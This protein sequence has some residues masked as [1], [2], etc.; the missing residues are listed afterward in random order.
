MRN[1]SA[2]Y[3]LHIVRIPQFETAGDFVGSLKLMFQ[4][5]DFQPS[6]IVPLAFFLPMKGNYN[7][8][9]SFFKYIKSVIP[10]RLLFTFCALF[11]NSAFYTFAIFRIPQSAFYRPL[12]YMFEGTSL[13]THLWIMLHHLELFEHIWLHC[14]VILQY[15]ANYSVHTR[16]LYTRFST[17]TTL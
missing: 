9:E 3:P 10:C 4:H 14:S 8:H 16:H 17:Y 15:T 1:D 11:H 5:T 13:L 2:F 12:S 6:L 7:V